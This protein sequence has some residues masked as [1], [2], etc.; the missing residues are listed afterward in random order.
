MDYQSILHLFL[1]ISFVIGRSSQ[2]ISIEPIA[3]PYTLSEGP[4]WDKENNVLY[5]V[6]IPKQ[7]IYCFNPETKH[8]THTHLS[9]GPV[10][11]AVPKAGKPN[12]FIAGSGTKLVQVLWDP[13]SDNLNP[14]VKVLATVDVDRNG[15]RFN[16]GKVDPAGRFWAGTMGEKN[17]VITNGQGTL[18]RF[19]NNGTPTKILSPVSISN[20]LTWNHN[21][22]TFYYIDSPTREIVSYNYNNITGDISNKC[23][24]FSLEENN[25]PGAPDGMTID[26][27]DN[28]WIAIYNGGRVI[29]VEPKSGKLLRTVN[30]PAAEI[31]SVAFGGSNFDVLYVTSASQ[32]LTEEQLKE[33]PYAG[34]VFAVHGLGVSGEEMLASK[35][36]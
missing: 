3:G 20:G 14:T 29:Q 26:K 21:N 18:Y 10:G 34:Y 8:I 33:Q 5:F 19:D 13:K 36:N 1:T 9:L 22:D 4:Y 27:A 11:V 32:S 6:D 31:T 24:V 28:L 2:Q 23:T 30:L 25:I 17:G 16:D 12:T 15:T 35:M 7:N